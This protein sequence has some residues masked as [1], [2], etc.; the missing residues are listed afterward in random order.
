[1]KRIAII[2]SR[3]MSSYGKEVIGLLMKELKDKAEIVTIEVM[4]CN[5]EVMKYKISKVF[6]GT[7]FEKLNE[8]LAEYADVLVVIEGGKNSGTIL[9]AAKFAE[10]NKNVYCVP[11]RIND[12]GSWAPNWLISQGAIPLTEVGDLTEG[13]TI[14]DNG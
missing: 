6:S 7:N 14:D 4:G 5:R 12:E 8:E 9:S 3:R 11:G 1:M 10:K 13:F 2:G